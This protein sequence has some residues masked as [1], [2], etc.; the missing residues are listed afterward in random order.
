MGKLD[1]SD[2][3]ARFKSW[4]FEAEYTANGDTFDIGATT[5]E[6]L[7]S[8]HGLDH[9]YSNGNGSL[10]RI[11]PLAFF[12]CTYKDIAKVSGITNGHLISIRAC[13]I[14]VDIAKGLLAGISFKDILPELKS[15]SDE[16]FE[17]LATIHQLEEEEIKSTGYVI[18]TLE[19]ALW[20]LANSRSYK[21]A[22]LRAV[23]LGEDTDTVAAVTGGLAG[24]QY[25]YQS[26]P[27][28]WIDKLRNKQL[29]DD[30]LQ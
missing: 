5:R 6:A 27:Q 25:G 20:C 3:Q 23:N 8:G 10:V 28:E 26:I 17:R 16:E 24:I 2:M 19:A 12:D 13:K 21:E 18:H 30:I 29:I 1:V 7:V 14:Y 4:A 15:Y 22:V 11:L 9:Y